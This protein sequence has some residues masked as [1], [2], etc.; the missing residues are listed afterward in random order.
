MIKIMLDSAS[1]QSQA[2]R[3]AYKL[4]NIPMPI[5]VGKKEFIDDNDNNFKVETLHHYMRE[6]KQPHTAQI[7]PQV[8]MD[9]FEAAA[10][11]GDD[12]IFISLS[13][14][15]SSSIQVAQKAMKEVEDR[16]PNFK[17]AVVDCRSASGAGTL[18]FLHGQA[19]IEAGY[20]FDQVRDQLDQSAQDMAVYVAVDDIEWLAKGGRV[21]KTFGKVGSMLQVKPL[22]TL[23]DEG[24]IKD[25]L[26]RGKDRVYTK[27][28]DK[29]IDHIS[30][31]QG[32][33][34]LVSHVGRRE[35][36][37]QVRDYITAKYGPVN[38]GIFEASPVISCHIG[39]GG[40]GVFAYKT[41]PDLFEPV[42]FKS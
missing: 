42:T 17:G 20:D 33:Y 35:M 5:T 36:A 12:V 11:E 30:P 19:L 24:F 18:L 40:L 26:V 16:Y 37:D 1:D 38:I 4:S 27:M 13:I 6:G 29:L 9:T 23:D 34:I 10:Q 28:A 2:L 32:Q 21:P 39:L 8:A 31:Y 14:R 3:E 7:S 22:L 41:K 25:S 15:L